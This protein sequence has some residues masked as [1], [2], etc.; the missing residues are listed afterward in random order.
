MRTRCSRPLAAM[1]FLASLA[2]L[3]SLTIPCARSFAGPTPAQDQNSQFNL[4]GKIT[5]LS[6]GKL[7]V[8]TEDNIIF[9]VTYGDKTEIHRKDG[10]TGSAKD[11]AEG[12][13]ITVEGMLTPA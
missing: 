3:S 8:S 4:E 6:P 5:D 1:I 9:H 11:L 2:A 7:T 12:E 13:T 10:T